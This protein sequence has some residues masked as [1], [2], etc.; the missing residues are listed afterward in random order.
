MSK[1]TD[2]TYCALT[3]EDFHPDGEPCCEDGGLP[4]EHPS[5]NEEN[6][7][8]ATAFADEIK[9]RLEYLRGEI[10]AERISTSELVELEGLSKYIDES[11][12]QLR[13]WAGITE[14]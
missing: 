7:R 1:H 12:V 6:G 3:R 9:E 14:N 4:E 2:T 10:N 13:E 8:E 11:D 5:S